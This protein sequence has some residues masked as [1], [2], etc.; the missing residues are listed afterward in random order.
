MI[1]IIFAGR[2]DNYGG[3]WNDRVLDT[4]QF[5]GRLLEERGIEFEYVYVEWNPLPDKPTFAE[6][7][8]ARFPF[9]R[10]VVVEPLVHQWVCG[11]KT[12]AVMEFHAKNVGARHAR[13]DWLLLTNPDNYFG[14]EVLDRLAGPLDPDTYYR[15]GR[16]DITSTDEIGAAHLEESCPDDKPPYPWGAGDFTLCS[17]ALFDRAGGYR[18]DLTFT[19][20]HKDAILVAT[21]FDLT[22]KTVK[23]GTTYHAV[24]VREMHA[25][26]RVEFKWKAASRVPQSS[27]GHDDIV[28]AHDVGDRLTRLTLREDLREQAAARVVPPA[29]VP[30]E[31]SMHRPWHK[32]GLKS[33]KTYLRAKGLLP[34]RR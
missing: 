11:N 7:L 19:N 27:Y 4:M 26:R 25:Q 2:N 23:S 8:E 13:G 21:L 1:S 30:R 16:T 20:T 14:D 32:R 9:V 3:H 10:C 24:H 34:Q 29:V 28:V 17:K 31:L 5:N 15:A 12:I 22:G 18:E 6:Q 33:V